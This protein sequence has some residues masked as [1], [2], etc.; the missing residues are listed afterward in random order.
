MIHWDLFF[1]YISSPIALILFLF[2]SCMVFPEFSWVEINGEIPFRALCSKDS[3]SS[4]AWLFVD[5][6]VSVSICCTRKV[7]S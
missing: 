3:L 2:S 4:N 5:L 7:L 6:S 1:W